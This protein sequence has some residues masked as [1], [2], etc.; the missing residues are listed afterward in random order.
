MQ[1]SNSDDLA[2]ARDF[3][4]RAAQWLQLI[5]FAAHRGAPVFSPSVCHYH[6]ML[7]PDATDT[8]RLAACRAMRG[9]V[10][11]RVQLEEQK[12]METWAM[13]RP[14]DPYRLHWRTT[15]DGAALS[16]IAHLLSAAIG[17]FETENQ[18]E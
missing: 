16:M 4:R 9:C 10:W 2:R 12:G 17:N 14:S 6:A 3:T 15:R 13:Q 8:A 7:D 5:G 18:A 11:R 1:H